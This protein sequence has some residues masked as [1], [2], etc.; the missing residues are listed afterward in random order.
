[1]NSGGTW[2]FRLMNSFVT[3]GL[4]KSGTSSVNRSIAAMS[5]FAR[6]E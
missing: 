2:R 6:F 5:A 1:M 3:C 4:S